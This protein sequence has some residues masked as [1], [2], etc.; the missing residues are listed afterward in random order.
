MTNSAPGGG[1]PPPRAHS[2]TGLEPATPGS[3]TEPTSGS[4]TDT[5]RQ[6]AGRVGQTAKEAGGQVA[7]SAA[8]QTRNVAAEAKGQARNLLNETQDQVREQAGIQKDRAAGGLR[9]L[10]DELRAMADG[11]PYGR[12]GI[13]SDI[14]RQ[15]ADR[16]QSFA[17]WLE[18]REPGDL[19][20]EARSLARRRPG[21]FLLGA[22]AAGVL[23]GRL[24]RGAVDA[25]RSE[26]DGRYESNGRHA[27]DTPVYAE[28][29]A[30]YP[31]EGLVTQEEIAVVETTEPYAS[32]TGRSTT[33]GGPL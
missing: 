11:T 32:T 17:G 15:A 33:G 24:T 28:T 23:A 8:E 4:T 29:A 6:Q 5:A 10:A 22:A 2:T 9:G 13:A 18:R 31:T 27:V 14:A 16:A 12:S 20:E 1:Y 7:S 30:G 19:V 26:S 3:S 21:T 25:K